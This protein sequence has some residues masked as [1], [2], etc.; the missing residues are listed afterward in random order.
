MIRDYYHPW[1][2]YLLRELRKDLSA[3]LNFNSNKQPKG[4]R[5]GSRD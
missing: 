3:L 1:W 2:L 4:N 5:Y